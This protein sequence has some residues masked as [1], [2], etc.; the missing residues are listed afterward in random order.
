MQGARDIVVALR[1]DQQ[2]PTAA[3]GDGRQYPVRAFEVRV[4]NDKETVVGLR[5]AFG[6]KMILACLAADEEA[7]AVDA[8]V[9]P[10]GRRKLL[11]IRP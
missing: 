7:Q 6:R 11:P 2:A 10:V 4:E 9:A 5:F 3:G 8:A 1:I